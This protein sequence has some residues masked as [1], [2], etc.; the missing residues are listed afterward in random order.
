MSPAVSSDDWSALELSWPGGPGEW[1]IYGG[2]I[3]LIILLSLFIT[4]KDTRFLPRWVTVLL[5]TLRL[6]LVVGLSVIALNP[7]ERTQKMSF[8]PSR[9]ALL[10]DTSL[11]MRFPEND[12]SEGETARD[13]NQPTRAQVVEQLLS[14]SEFLNKLQQEHEV[15][16]YTFDTELHGPHTVYPSLDRRGVKP[17]AETASPDTESVA[18][19]SQTAS[20]ESSTPSLNWEEILQPQG[21]E[22]RLGE[23][24]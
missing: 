20:P 7:Q 13:T 14:D 5:G 2:G 8:R 4:Y 3:L 18:D 12:L 17:G 19:E 22:T 21:A 6:L 10:V 9:V 1:A 15:S 11:S 16:L 24:W 23:R